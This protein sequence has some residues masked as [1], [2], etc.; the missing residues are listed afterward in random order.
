MVPFLLHGVIARPV[1]VHLL[2]HLALVTDPCNEVPYW[3][4]EV[5]T[6]VIRLLTRRYT[7]MTR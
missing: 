2:P 5:V 1:Q 6:L 4:G 3:R 7:P